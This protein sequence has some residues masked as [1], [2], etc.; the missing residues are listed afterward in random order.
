MDI[1]SLR[2]RVQQFWDESYS[3]PTTI[4]KAK[5]L[6]PP[7]KVSEVSEVLQLMGFRTTWSGMSGIFTL[8]V[9]GRSYDWIEEAD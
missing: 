7:P 5:G 3:I 2:E 1:S 6:V 4:A 9:N 8:I